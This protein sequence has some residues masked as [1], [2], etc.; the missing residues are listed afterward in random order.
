M[1]CDHST[2]VRHLHSIGKIKKSGAWVPHALSQ[3]HRSQRVAIC[4]SLL[5]RHR[6]ACEKH[7]PF[8][9]CIVTGDEKW[10]IHANIR[11][12]KEWLSSNK[13]KLPVEKPARI[14]K[15]WCYA[16]GGTAKVCSTTNCFIGF[17]H[18]Y[19]HLLS[20][21]ETSRRRNPKEDRQNGGRWCYSTITPARTLLTW[22]KTIYRS[23]VG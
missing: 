2:I 13:K 7:R 3:N 1:N 20:V 18:H 19:W 6:L 11:R 4:A 15:K 8:L 9:S 21:T 14:H 12:R 5:A 17:Y 10:C 16:T 23:W 22:Q